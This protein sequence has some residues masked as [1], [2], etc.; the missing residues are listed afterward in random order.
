MNRSTGNYEAV[1]APAGGV[2]VN[3]GDA[4]QFWTSDLLVANV[5][6]Y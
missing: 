6:V 1:V 5:S 4:L 3:I 2:I